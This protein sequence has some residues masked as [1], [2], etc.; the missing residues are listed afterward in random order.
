VTAF[1]PR[2]WRCAGCN[3]YNTGPR[4]VKC[5]GAKED[6]K[7]HVPPPPIGVVSS[8]YRERRRDRAQFAALPIPPRYVATNNAAEVLAK[9]YEARL[10]TLLIR[11]GQDDVQLALIKCGLLHVLDTPSRRQL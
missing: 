1:D 2:T 10:R 6:V 4:C 9:L 5:G 3:V 7:A 11:L 8:S